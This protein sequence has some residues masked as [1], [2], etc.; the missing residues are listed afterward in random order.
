MTKHI[1]A[2]MTVLF[3]GAAVVEGAEPIRSRKDPRFKPARPAL[4]PFPDVGSENCVGIPVIASL[5]FLDTGDTCG[6]ANDVQSPTGCGLP[7]GYGG[8]DV[9]YQVNVGAMN[10]VAFSLDLTGSTGDLALYVLAACG[11]ALACVSSAD[12]IGV[13][14]PENIAPQSYGGGSGGILYVY[15][16]SYYASPIAGNCG[17]Y[18]LTA[19]GTL[20][21]ELVEFSVD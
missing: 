9:L 17:T 5:P 12:D 6:F 15:V 13:A 14:V 11:D 4:Q 18:T 20:P 16:D 3:V 7:A 10:S 1:L 19:S 8:P 2:I 21:A